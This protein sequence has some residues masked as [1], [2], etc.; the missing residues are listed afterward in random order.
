MPSL[1][2]IAN[3]EFTGS[4][5][6][7][8][9]ALGIQFGLAGQETLPPALVAYFAMGIGA[10]VGCL[11]KGSDFNPSVSM[12]NFLLGKGG[13]DPMQ[14][15]ARIVAQFLGMFGAAM[16]TWLMTSDIYST[17]FVPNR[18]AEP[19]IEW[20]WAQQFLMVA[21]ASGPG[22]WLLEQYSNRQLGHFLTY[23]YQALFS[24]QYNGGHFNWMHTLV[25]GLSAELQNR[26]TYTSD[27][28]EKFW[29]AFIVI[30]LGNLLSP[31]IAYGQGEF[32]WPGVQKVIDELE[33]GEKNTEEEN[34]SGL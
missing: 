2:E 1:A 30:V 10:A 7:F 17:H 26:D 32:A 8:S 4:F 28:R 31:L 16:G 21:L 3:L 27:M 6:Y 9:T 12:T 19:T 23:G 22:I 14:L 15:V 5:F 24:F 25:V 20:K 34:Q 18:L 33:A 11:V 29:K 13:R